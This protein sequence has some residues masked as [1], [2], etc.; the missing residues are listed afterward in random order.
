MPE[1]YRVKVRPGEVGPDAVLPA[2]G[3]FWPART[4]V[5]PDEVPASTLQLLERDPRF[6]VERIPDD[7]PP[8]ESPGGDPP[9]DPKLPPGGRRPRKT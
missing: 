6:D 3:R 5:T 9:R 1:R 2:Y 8:E 4:D 7:P